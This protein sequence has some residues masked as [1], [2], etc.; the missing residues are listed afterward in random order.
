MEF[1][2]RSL[3]W[4]TKTKKKIKMTNEFLRNS[5]MFS[6][7]L[8]LFVVYLV[9]CGLLLFTN[10]S[11][12][13]EGMMRSHSCQNSNRIKVAKDISIF[14][15]YA[16][17]MVGKSVQTWK[18]KIVLFCKVKLSKIVSTRTNK[19]KKQTALFYSNFL[20]YTD[21]LLIQ[22]KILRL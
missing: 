21:L 3:E 5:K 6:Q 17:K 16:A 12:L 9:V 14:L 22:K 4:K 8:L 20:R 19:I 11:G 10:H 7:W 18:G 13:P 15:I 1:V 2:I